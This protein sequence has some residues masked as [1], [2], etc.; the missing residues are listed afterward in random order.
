MNHCRLSYAACHRHE[1]KIHYGYF[2]T[3][4]VPAAYQFRIMIAE[5]LFCYFGECYVTI[6]HA[7]GGD[8]QQSLQL[9][10]SYRR[11]IQ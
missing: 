9:L 8:T 5:Y 7:S 1:W 2:D 10:L 4:R 11:T 3:L 6:L